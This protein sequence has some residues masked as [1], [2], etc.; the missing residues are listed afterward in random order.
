MKAAINPGDGGD[1]VGF[2]LRCR[3]CRPVAPASP[4][5]CRRRWNDPSRPVDG[6]PAPDR[7]EQATS[8]QCPSGCRASD[9]AMPTGPNGL[10]GCPDPV[11][12]PSTNLSN[13][14]P[15]AA[16]SG[17]NIESVQ[18]GR[19]SGL[20]KLDRDMDYNG[21]ERRRNSRW[22]GRS[23]PWTLGAELGACVPGWSRMLAA[24]IGSK[25]T[26]KHWEEKGEISPVQACKLAAAYTVRIPVS[27][28]PARGAE[29]DFRARDP[30]KTVP[31]R[32]TAGPRFPAC[33]D[34][35]WLH[36]ELS[37]LGAFPCSR[38]LAQTT[39]S[40]KLPTSFAGK[41]TLHP[42]GLE[43]QQRGAKHDA[44]SLAPS[45]LQVYS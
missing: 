28:P 27:P 17:S 43:I 15:T 21:R 38:V 45:K 5:S 16:M 26:L 32:R 8:A 2:R 13:D 20:H 35:R 25:C 33:S 37:R 6:H 42:T 18:V 19:I 24:K 10:C 11:A 34:G 22:P 7:P 41:L 12:H 23:S 30:I 14:R 40:G 9:R 4:A 36:E 44:S 3:N 31:Q 39:Q 29:S 1:H